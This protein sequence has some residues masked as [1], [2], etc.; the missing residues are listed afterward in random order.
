MNTHQLLR[1][2]K[3][4]QEKAQLRAVTLK[5]ARLLSATG[6]LFALA[7]PAQ[8]APLVAGPLLV[9]D[10]FAV[11]DT[12]WCLSVN[13]GTKPIEMTVVIAFDGVSTL[14]V[15]LQPGEVSRLWAH[16]FTSLSL[17]GYCSFDVTKGGKKNLRAT[18]CVDVGAGQGCGAAVPAV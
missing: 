16:N 9:D 17:T 7:S 6:L 11:G 5:W 10:N 18:A 3:S 12:L 2:P 8:A 4:A 13:I 14:D 1:I 15:T